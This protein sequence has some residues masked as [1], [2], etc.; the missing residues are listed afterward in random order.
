MWLSPTRIPQVSRDIVRAIVSS[1][2]IETSAVHEVE[3]DIEAV[4]EQYV[5]DEREIQ[6]RAGSLARS[7]NLPP[8]EA[9]RI[10]HDLARERNIGLGEDAIDYVLDQLVEML[11]NSSAVDEVYAE[12]FELKRKMREPL[13][14][15]YA[16][17]D[18]IDAEIRSRMKHLSE[19]SSVWEVEY[20]RLRDE[21]KH[22]R[23]M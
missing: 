10:K 23:G 4:L 13:R 16:A 3:R 19:G 15:E 11:M 21:V 6:D 17:R 1:K 22:R 12:D 18:T 20:A 14:A 5:R 8:A 9:S 7:R 2:S